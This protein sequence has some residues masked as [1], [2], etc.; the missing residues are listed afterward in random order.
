V[1]FA[2]SSGLA[3]AV[4]N[5]IAAGLLAKFQRSSDQR[6][7]R[8]LQESQQSF[9]E[10]MQKDARENESLQLLIK[11]HFE[12]RDRLLEAAIESYNWVYRQIFENY[13]FQN[14][15]YEYH[16]PSPRF[17]SAS[18]VIG[19]LRVISQ[20]HPTRSVRQLAGRLKD[21]IAGHYSTLT[22]YG[23]E[24]D[25]PIVGGTPSENQLFDWLKESDALIEMLHT[26][27][28]LDEVR[29]SVVATSSD[30]LPASLP[31]ATSCEIPGRRTNLPYQRPES[32]IPLQAVSLAGAEPEASE[33]APATT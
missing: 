30:L 1:V 14:E 6:H 31:A 15:V 19:S 13:G 12:Q 7:Q 20:T 21:R 9:Q 26:P 24:H 2:L 27:P 25:E 11:S 28:S 16:G 10:R 23:E 3:A 29:V 32:E 8:A 5:Q 18:D 22:G 33:A 17:S 4:F